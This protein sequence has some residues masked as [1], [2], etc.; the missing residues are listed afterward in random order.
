MRAMVVGCMM[1]PI[2][3][4]WLHR[5]NEEHHCAHFVP[6]LSTAG[7]LDVAMQDQGSRTRWL[8]P[9]PA[10]RRRTTAA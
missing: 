4:P 3:R 6:A 5:G 1:R 9:G 10:L 7:F 2:V 8:Q